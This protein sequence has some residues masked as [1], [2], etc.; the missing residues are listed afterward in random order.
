VDE[1]DD[2]CAGRDRCSPRSQLQV[3]EREDE[4]DEQEGEPDEPELR[5]HLQVEGMRVQRAAARCDEP[6]PHPGERERPCAGADGDVPLELLPGD[7][8]Q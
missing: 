6:G 4:E 2:V 3:C 1:E 5:E 7:A 8:P